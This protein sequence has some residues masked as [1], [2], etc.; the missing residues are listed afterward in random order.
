MNPEV[1]K[2]LIK[3]LEQLIACDSAGVGR[4]VVADGYSAIDNHFSALILSQGMN[5]PFNH[6][7]KLGVALN[8][9]GTALRKLGIKQAELTEFYEL[10]Q[11]SRYSME[12]VSPSDSYKYRMITNKVCGIVVEDIAKRQDSA[13]EA[14][15]QLVYEKL[16]GTRWQKYQDA[17]SHIH[18]VWQA[19]LEQLG[20]MGYGKKLGNK[21]ANPSNF[22]ELTLIS[23]DDVTKEALAETDVINKEVAELYDAYLRLVTK[24]REYRHSK[25]VEDNE[26]PN[27]SLSLRMRYSGETVKEVAERFG[28]AMQKALRS[29]TEI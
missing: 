6:R 11:K 21:L 17:V 14:I 5:N 18:E 20:E 19:E 27:F 24:L 2:K 10:W 16:L 28:K 15:E 26:I 12:P 3:G 13:P 4:S 23:D 1:E 22:C 29:I 25:D 9:L 8:L 7:K